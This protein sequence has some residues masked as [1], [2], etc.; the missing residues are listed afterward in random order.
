MGALPLERRR[1]AAALW[2]RRVGWFGMILMLTAGTVRHFGL[3][4]VPDFLT[5]AAL[6]TA[7]AVFALLLAAVGF[8]RLW[9]NGDVAG[10]NGLVACFTALPTLVPLGFALVLGWLYP[11][12]GDVSTDVVS[13]P[14]LTAVERDG[15]MNAIRPIVPEQ[16]RLQR[17]LFPEVTGRRY[18]VPA[19][20]VWT[21]I[22]K[23]AD[24]RGWIVLEAPNDITGLSEATLEAVAETLLLRFPRDVAI[25]VTD[26][27]TTTYVDMRSASRYGRRDF[28]DNARLVGGFLLELDRAIAGPTGG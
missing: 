20:T 19:E 28:G 7:F 21:A 17:S 22:R 26:E 13:P 3:L 2:A 4:A 10:R 16:A 5:V 8:A 9:R 14:A 27:D 1:S 11:T 24:D 23:L 6:A 12:V 25:R 15:T 18:A